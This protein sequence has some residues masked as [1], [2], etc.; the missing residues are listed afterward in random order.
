MMSSLHVSVKDSYL[1]ST[2]NF[3]SVKRLG[4]GAG[5]GWVGEQ[6]GSS[7]VLQMDRSVKDIQRLTRS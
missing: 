6:A 3:L 2:K 5:G 1:Q 7:L 4:E